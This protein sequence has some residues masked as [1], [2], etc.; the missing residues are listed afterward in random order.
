MEEPDDCKETSPPPQDACFEEVTA[1]FPDICLNYLQPIA[2]ELEFIA[3]DVINH[4][5]D[6]EDSGQTYT[7]RPK[8]TSKKRKREADDQNDKQKDKVLEAKRRYIDPHRPALPKNSPQANVMKQ[9]IAGD[10]PLVPIRTIQQLLAENNYHLFPTFTAVDN[11]T[12][13]L[14]KASLSWKYKK[15]PSVQ[16]GKYKADT[17][18]ASIESC[19]IDWE[20]ELMK[21]LQAARLVQSDAAEKDRVKTLAEETERRNFEEAEARGELTE[22]GCCFADVPPNRLVYCNGDVTHSFCLDCCR[23][24]AETQIGLEKYGLECLSTDGCGAGFSYSERKKFLDKKLT[25]A[26][27]RIEQ[28]ANIREAMLPN[29]AQCPFCQYAEEYPPADIDREFR[30]RNADCMITSCRLCNFETHI[31]KTCDEATLERG[32]D[33]RREVEEAMSGA[34][35]RKC[36]KCKHFN[37][38]SRGGTKGNC[39]LFDSVEERHE[40]DIKE[41]EKAARK[42]VLEENPGLA[43]DFLDFRIS[44]KVKKDDNRRKHREQRI[45]DRGLFG[46]RPEG[47]AILNFMEGMQQENQPQDLLVAPQQQQPQPQPQQDM[48]D[49]RLRRHLKH[50]AAHH[51]IN[52]GGAIPVPPAAPFPGNYQGVQ[53]MPQQ[54]QMPQLQQIHQLPPEQQ[55]FLAM[56]PLE[57]AAFQA[58]MPYQY[59]PF[60]PFDNQNNRQQ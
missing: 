6:L 23:R 60:Q 52:D 34:L 38:E 42:K 46:M 19:S 17:I 4:I 35:I 32:V 51:H 37:D 16:P 31:P 8:Q 26:L 58:G 27:D 30:C 41:A 20:K 59:R 15:T 21:E 54:Q 47:R 2:K 57:W 7:K 14:D 22:C 18:D 29:L 56:N 1:V 55:Q 28:T 36:N 33:V 40:N 11:A 9:M 39:P 12:T 25:S 10:F 3:Q 53:W 13:R 49:L 45:R 50:A 43:P 44:K 48:P 24:N 5:L